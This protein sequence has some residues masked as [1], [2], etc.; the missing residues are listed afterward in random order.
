[1]FARHRPKVQVQA[2]TSLPDQTAPLV[3]FGNPSASRVLAIWQDRLPTS[4]NVKLRS[5]WI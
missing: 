4:S 3:S 1:M 2:A 5:P